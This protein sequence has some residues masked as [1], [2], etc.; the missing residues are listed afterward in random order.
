MMA[1]GWAGSGGGLGV[2]ET[3]RG[4][5]HWRKNTDVGDVNVYMEGIDMNHSREKGIEL[6]M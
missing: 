4:G 2:G 3:E 5:A 6:A 1:N